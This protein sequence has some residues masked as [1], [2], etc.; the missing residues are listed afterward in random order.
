MGSELEEDGAVVAAHEPCHRRASA[1]GFGP[2]NR[3]TA[4]HLPGDEGVIDPHALMM[5]EESSARKES[6]R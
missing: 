1:Q 2:H 6:G 3:R 4:V 5:V